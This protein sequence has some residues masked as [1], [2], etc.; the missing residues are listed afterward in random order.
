VEVVEDIVV[1]V[2]LVVLVLV[3][4]VRVFDVPSVLRDGI[5]G[6]NC[7]RGA[8]LEKYHFVCFASGP[9]AYAGFKPKQRHE[10]RYHPT[11]SSSNTSLQSI[12]RSVARVHGQQC[13]GMGSNIILA[14]N[15]NHD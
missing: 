13:S 6:D 2:A 7:Q 9:H 3:V 15:N 1:L 12:Q 8:H 5:D 14:S 10:V 4:V 11:S